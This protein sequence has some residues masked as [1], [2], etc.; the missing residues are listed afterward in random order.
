[1]KKDDS[2]TVIAP[3]HPYLNRTGKIEKV[4]ANAEFPFLVNLDGKK[5]WFYERE[6]R[7]D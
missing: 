3:Y 1:M 4:E 2:V 7:K 6:I 5:E